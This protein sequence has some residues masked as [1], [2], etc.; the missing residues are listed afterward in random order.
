MPMPCKVCGSPARERIEQAYCGGTGYIGVA[1]AAGI[2]KSAAARHCQH[3][4]S[5]ALARYG[6]Q[7][8][9]Q[10]E[11]LRAERLFDELERLRR[12]AASLLDKAEAAKDF[13]A[14]AAAIREGREL[15]E[16]SARLE[17]RIR[18]AK[19]KVELFAVDERAAFRIA[20]AFM[21]SRG[22]LP[23]PGRTYDGEAVDA[24]AESAT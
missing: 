24:E 10:A 20:S 2:S 16:L 1:A 15:L 3:H 22:A 17:G 4:L 21:A 5:A 11:T 12:R 19:L 9:A 13:R 18:D 23:L 8:P 7:H 14:A 6:E